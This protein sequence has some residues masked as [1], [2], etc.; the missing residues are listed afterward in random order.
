MVKCFRLF[1]NSSVSKFGSNSKNTPQVRLQEYNTTYALCVCLLYAK[2]T[3]WKCLQPLQFL[4]TLFVNFL[5]QGIQYLS[6]TLAIVRPTSSWSVLTWVYCTIFA[7]SKAV[8]GRYTGYS[9]WIRPQHLSTPSSLG[10]R[11]SCSWSCSKLALLNSCGWA[12]L[13]KNVSCHVTSATVS[14]PL[15][16]LV[17][18]WELCKNRDTQ[19]PIFK[20]LRKSNFSRTTTKSLS[21][22]TPTAN[23]SGCVGFKML[24]GSAVQYLQQILLL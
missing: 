20:A 3:A 9:P 1:M 13:T 19:A 10:C 6:L 17:E 21:S 24:R 18:F 14:G 11:F 22:S 15:A 23:H 5:R 8:S 12:L 7:A 16:L 2:A 4:T